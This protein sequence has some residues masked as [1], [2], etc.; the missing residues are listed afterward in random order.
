[1][2]R[3]LRLTLAALA[4]T[5]VLS[6]ASRADEGERF[7]V[8]SALVDGQWRCSIFA[9]RASARELIGALA[10]QCDVTLEGFEH[11]SRTALVD[12]D[13][14]DR[15]V[16]QALEYVLGSV[17]LRLETRRGVWRVRASLRT[18]AEPET[19]REQALTAYLGAL[20]DFPDHLGGAGALLSQGE[21][22]Q[23]RGHL[24]AARERFDGVVESYPDSELVAE[25]LMRAGLTLVRL[26]DWEQ[27]AV[28]FADL[29]RLERVHPFEVPARLEL[30][31]CTVALGEGQ[32]ALAMLDALD[33]IHPAE[34]GAQARARLLV[35]AGA[36][37][38]TGALEEAATDLAWLELQ[39]L[40]HDARREVLELSARA[41]EGLERPAEAA[42][43]WLAYSQESEGGERT[44]GLRH[45]ARLALAAG[46]EVAVL[47]IQELAEREGAGGS[48]GPQ[49]D[50]AR[51]RLALGALAGGGATSTRRIERAEELVDAGSALEALELLDAVERSGSR[52]EP[53]ALLRAGLTRGRALARVQGVEAAVGALRALVPQLQDGDARRA[54]YLLAGELLE[55]AGHVDAA[56]EAYQGRL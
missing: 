49:A 36:L 31:R 6:A 42:R 8:R 24:A 9:E 51:E 18:P 52:L 22:E 3:A 5:L 10:R 56:I 48:L 12:A 50:V 29:L 34:D 17:G 33:S 20:R 13:L 43:R 40:P 47:F 27:A 19:L 14:R 39:P 38:A 1:M 25:A 2:S 53:A 44:I 28:R 11:V 26:R 30:A 21:I 45:A 15:P 41:L 46:D 23:A 4:A 16:H 7:Q 55:Q 35:R 32:R 54:V 37:V